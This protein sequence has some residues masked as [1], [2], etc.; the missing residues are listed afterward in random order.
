MKTPGV[1]ARSLLLDL[2]C[3]EDRAA[4]RG[5]LRLDGFRKAARAYLVQ[6]LLRRASRSGYVTLLAP[7]KAREIAA[8]VQGRHH[9][10][11]VFS[12]A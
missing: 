6:R 2:I 5:S 9:L 10:D 3:R 8:R 7:A 4:V 11:L 12:P 1:R